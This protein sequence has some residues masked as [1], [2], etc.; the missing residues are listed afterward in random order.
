MLTKPTQPDH[1]V[2]PPDSLAVSPSS[3]ATGWYLVGVLLI[4]NIFSFVDRQ[5]L[6]LLVE[7]I[8]HDLMLSDTSLSLLQG[9]A[10]TLFYSLLSLPLGRIIDR[11]N[12]R[13][14]L[15]A[16][17][18]IWSLATIACGLANNYPQLFIARI[19]V[20]IGEATLAPAAYSMI[21]DS[22]PPQKRGAA[23]GTFTS[24]TYLGIGIAVLLGGIVIGFIAGHDH[25]SLWLFGSVRPWQAAFIAVGLPGI[26]VVALLLTLREPVRTLPVQLRQK[27]TADPALIWARKKARLLAP[28][29][30]GY[31]LMGLATFGSGTWVPSLMIRIHHWSAQQAALYYGLALM[32]FGTAGGILSGIVADKWLSRKNYGARVDLSTLCAICWLP[33][34]VAASLVSDGWVSLAFF[35]I[36]SCFSSAVN[37]L[38]PT[39]VQD[40]VP[41]YLRGQVTALFFFVVNLLG[42]GIGPTAVALV[43]DQIFG[44]HPEALRFAIPIVAIPAAIAGVLL[45]FYGRKAFINEVTSEK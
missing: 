2:S 18:A 19:V 40:I 33:M 27:G 22:F 11:T 32:V 31:T 7:P 34:I 20:G 44:G 43:T 13:N 17:V 26:I 8:K 45:L 38:G 4:T 36:A 10:F 37:C 25:V 24:G 21:A 14:L 39:A 16:G 29:M 9:F 3:L 28:V 6:V 42:L 35:G 30:L 41:P 5:I 23:L 12:R 15:L 1:R